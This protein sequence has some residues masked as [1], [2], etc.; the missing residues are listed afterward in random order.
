MTRHRRPGEERMRPDH[1]DHP[2]YYATLGLPATATPRQITDAYRALA[3]A[4]HP[5]T[6]NTTN[7]TNTGTASFGGDTLAR[8]TAATTAYQVLH[9]P[10]R[11]AAYDASCDRTPHTPPAARSPLGAPLGVPWIHTTL[12]MAGLACRPSETAPTANPS[13]LPAQRFIGFIDSATREP[14]LRAGPVHIT[15]LP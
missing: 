12:H 4:L 3:R 13:A 8:F 11:R 7:T 14:L 10:V 6:T 5:D 9:D 15:P 1:P 2:D